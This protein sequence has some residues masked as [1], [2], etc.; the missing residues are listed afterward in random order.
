[1]LDPDQH[2]M[3]IAGEFGFRNAERRHILD[4]SVSFCS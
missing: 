1:V 3:D 2:S 4:D